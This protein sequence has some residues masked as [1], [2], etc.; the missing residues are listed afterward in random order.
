MDQNTHLSLS[1]YNIDKVNFNLTFQGKLIM[2]C[3]CQVICPGPW[4][5]RDGWDLHWSCIFRELHY[6]AKSR[7]SPRPAG[8]FYCVNPRLLTKKHQGMMWHEKLTFLKDPD[9]E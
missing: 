8:Q 5:P 2:L 3:T 7:P 4:V 9:I 6:P 1:L